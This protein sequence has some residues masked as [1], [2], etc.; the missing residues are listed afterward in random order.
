MQPSTLALS[1]FLHL[2]ATVIWIGGLLTTLLLVWP[3]ARRTLDQNPAAYRFLSRIRT[4]FFPLSHLS[5]SRSSSRA[6][7][8]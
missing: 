8:R 2:L 4:G 6:C 7:S 5:S 3:A 1:L